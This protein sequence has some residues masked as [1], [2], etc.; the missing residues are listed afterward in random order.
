MQCAIV[1]HNP[2]AMCVMVHRL[3]LKVVAGAVT[4]GSARNFSRLL[5]LSP[6]ASQLLISCFALLYTPPNHE[7]L[8]TQGPE[9]EEPTNQPCMH[10]A[11][12]Y[13]SS[14]V[15]FLKNFVTQEQKL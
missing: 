13:P 15:I 9:T 4:L 12:T 8:F 5:F 1:G 11:T 2:S 14:C 7:V 6:Y 10:R 3:V